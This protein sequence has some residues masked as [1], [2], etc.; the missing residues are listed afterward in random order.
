MQH[1]TS[2][3][4]QSD[5]HPI[6]GG[7]ASGN[8]GLQQLLQFTMT[9]ASS[10]PRSGLIV[11]MALIALAVGG[12]T[13]KMT[14]P[15]KA[16]APVNVPLNSEPAITP[17]TTVLGVEPAGPTRDAAATTSKAKTDVSK[18]QQSTAMPLPGQAN[19]HSVLIPP[20]SPQ[21]AASR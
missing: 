21:R 19:D 15:I 9:N 3:Y 5:I 18:E 2:S 14:P 10:P 17:S 8:D 7:A 20:G 6:W 11:V 1:A 12:C 4:T 13:D 16:S